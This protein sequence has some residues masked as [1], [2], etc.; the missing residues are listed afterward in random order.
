MVILEQKCTLLCNKKSHLV[1]D[2]CHHKSPYMW[3]R[4]KFSVTS[5]KEMTALVIKKLHLISISITYRRNIS[6]Q[7]LSIEY[8]FNN[9][10]DKEAPFYH[11]PNLI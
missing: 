3:D 6:G 9:T 4:E 11:C 1:Y 7:C 2:Y 8:R 10:L 5:I